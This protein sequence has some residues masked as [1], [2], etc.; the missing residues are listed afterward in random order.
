[1]IA[2]P[3]VVNHRAKVSATPYTGLAFSSVLSEAVAATTESV[4]LSCPNSGAGRGFSTGLLDGFGQGGS[5]RKAERLASDKLLTPCPPIAS[6]SANGGF[7][8]PEGAEALSQSPSTP[9]SG[10]V[11]PFPGSLAAPIIQRRRP[12]P[13]PKGIGSVVKAREARVMAKYYAAKSRRTVAE[14]DESIAAHSNRIE[15][16]ETLWR[17]SIARRAAAMVER[18]KAVTV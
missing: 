4:A 17:E 12:G 18:Q 1:M 10:I 14:L 2:T 13:L 11:I 5:V 8:S 3:S 15:A 7:L 16:C 9:A 6:S